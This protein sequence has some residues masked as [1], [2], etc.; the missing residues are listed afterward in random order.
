MKKLTLL[1]I[2]CMLSMLAVAQTD[3]IT[4]PAEQGTSQMLVTNGCVGLT[5]DS[6]DYGNQPVDFATTS[7]LFI[8]SNGCAVSV[9]VTNVNAQGQSFSQTNGC[10]I[11]LPNSSC[12]IHVTFDPISAGA[13]SQNLVITY[14]KQ[15]NPNP[16]QISAG[17]SGTGIH[18]LTF[19][20]TSCD[21]ITFVIDEQGSEGFCT[22]TVQNQEPESITIDHCR[23]SPAP[24][25]S[26]D[27]SCPMSLAQNDSVNIR[28]DFQVDYPGTYFGQFAVTTDSPE[29][30]QTMNPYIVPLLGVAHGICPPPCCQGSGIVCPPS[31]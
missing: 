25:F 16:M 10:G 5:P 4:S 13:K 12:D 18:D 17:L 8:L 15:G 24:P 30:H 14:L 27:T 2:V 31:N 6:R 1:F 7:R 22:V 21:F 28:L 23:V 11:L 26:Q 20:P 29:E 3:S 9:T 19:S